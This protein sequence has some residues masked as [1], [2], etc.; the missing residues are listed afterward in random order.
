MFVFL[1]RLIYY[2]RYTRDFVKAASNRFAIDEKIIGGSFDTT[3]KPARTEIIEPP[4]IA[5]S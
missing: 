4:I 5:I 1:F 2:I 3:Y